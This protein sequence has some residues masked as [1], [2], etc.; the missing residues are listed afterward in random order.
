MFT[1]VISSERD[2]QKAYS[3]FTIAGKT[4]DVSKQLNQLSSQLNH[5]AADGATAPR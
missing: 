5:Q 3:L 1:A 4:L 2:E